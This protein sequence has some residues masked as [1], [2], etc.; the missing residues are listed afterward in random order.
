VH[1]A[2]LA[3]F[4]NKLGRYSR[5]EY[6]ISGVFRHALV[7]LLGRDKQ[8][9]AHA[10]AMDGLLGEVQEVHEMAAT[11]EPQLRQTMAELEC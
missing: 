1:Y 4:C 10:C 7:T 5:A 11:V 8:L 2:S 6:W 9:R 3:R